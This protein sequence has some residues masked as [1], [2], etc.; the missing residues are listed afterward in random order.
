MS[1]AERKRRQDYKKNRK[2]W[3]TIQIIAIALIAVIALSSFIVY[4][5]MDRTYYIH[6][7]ENGN[8]DY[9]VHLK[10]NEFFEDEWV[11]KDQAYISSLINNIVADFQYKLNMDTSNVSFDYSYGIN[12]QLVIADRDSGAAIFDPTYVL[13]PKTNVTVNKGNSIT[14]NESVEVDYVRYNELAKSFINTYDLKSVTS[15]L[16]VKLDVEV[17]SQCDAFEENSENTYTIALNIPLNANTVKIKL[18]SGVPAAESKVLACTP[19][20][21]QNV[22]KN[23]GISGI[24]IDVVLAMVLVAFIHLTKNEDINYSNKVKKLVSAYRSYIQQINGDFD[25]AGHQVVKIKTFVEMLGI[26]DTIQSPILM[27]EN[28]DQTRTQ[29]IIPTNTD[30]VYLFEIK[31]DNYD[32]IYGP[33]E[34]EIEI[35]IVEQPIA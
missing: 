29:F 11:G 22:F 19:A 8:V 3:L 9:K 33:A 27:S 4:N 1:E 24:A 12:A 6:Y 10:E 14:I 34:P 16:V 17:L 30:L 23:I 2:K 20:I 25:T 5:R 26:R 32:D 15:T 31:I 7:T 18:T 35:E 21:N 28:A 13:V